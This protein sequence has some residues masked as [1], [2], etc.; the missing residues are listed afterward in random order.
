MITMQAISTSLR[1]AINWLG[2]AVSGGWFSL[3]LSGCSGGENYFN[4][5][6]EI[7]QDNRPNHY[8]DRPQR[9]G[10]LLKNNSGRYGDRVT[11]PI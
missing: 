4:L 10:A 2:F 11:V 1:K 3:S 7:H 5:G 6:I 8:S 9:V